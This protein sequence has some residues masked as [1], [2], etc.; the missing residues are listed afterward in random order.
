MNMPVKNPNVE[1]IHSYNVDIPRRVIYLHSENEPGEP[2]EAGVDFKMTQRFIKNIDILN[3]K[4][5]TPI[6][7]KMFSCGGCWNYGMAIFDAIRHSAAPVSFESFA[8]ARSMSSIIPQAAKTRRIHRHCDFMI[9]YGTYSDSGE[10]RQVMSGAKFAEGS[11]DQMLNIYV[12]RCIKGQYAKEKGL[13]KKELM[14]DFRCRTEKKTDWWMTPEEAVYYG[15]MD[16][17][18][19]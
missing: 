13:D 15:F 6:T 2:E 16:E 3:A 10:W 12:D 14:E 5:K 18:I 9:H 19:T 7:V 1:E 4:A 17:V 8:H 11:V